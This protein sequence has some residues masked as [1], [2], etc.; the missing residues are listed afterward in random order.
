M[1]QGLAER[2]FI[3]RKGGQAVLIAGFDADGAEEGAV[4]AAGGHCGAQGAVQGGEVPVHKQDAGFGFLLVGLDLALG[5]VCLILVSQGLVPG[6]VRLLQRH[7]GVGLFDLGHNG[8]VVLHHGLDHVNDLVRVGLTG[9]GDRG[10][11]I[12]HL[13]CAV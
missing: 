11:S 2:V 3:Q 4:G 10:F 6:A 1:F 5:H 12:F 8:V 13:K 7:V 9:E